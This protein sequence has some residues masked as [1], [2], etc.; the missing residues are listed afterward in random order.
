MNSQ[1]DLVSLVKGFQGVANFHAVER[2]MAMFADDAEFEIV[3]LFTLVGKQQIRAIFEYDAGVNAELQF[4][5]CTYEGDTVTCQLVERN[6]RL[7]ATGISELHYPSCVLTFKDRLIKKFTA[8]LPAESARTI[9]EMWQAFLPWIAKNYPADY[10]KMFT[11]EGRFIYN[12]ENGERVIP[13]LK[14]W[15]ASEGK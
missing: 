6:D 4:I 13:L 7:E 8:T 2:V 5:N 15:R 9:G 10:S 3:G 11:S 12:R 1:N 14:E